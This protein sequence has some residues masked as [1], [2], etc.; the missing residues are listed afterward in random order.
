MMLLNQCVF[1]IYRKLNK[2]R[3]INFESICPPLLLQP[4]T[5]IANKEII[6]LT[7]LNKLKLNSQYFGNW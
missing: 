2:K 3:K 6:I 7:G 1:E 5:S 4:V